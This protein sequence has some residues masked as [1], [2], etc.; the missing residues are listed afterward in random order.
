MKKATLQII[1]VNYNSND[2]LMA[3]LESIQR[4]CRDLVVET[5]V[6]DNGSKNKPGLAIRKRFPSIILVENEKN[7]GFAAAVNEV[8][9]QSDTPFILLLNPD[10]VIWTGF[11][12]KA[13]N[14]ILSHPD[15]G[16]MGPRIL[17]SDGSLQESARAFPNGLTAIFG[18]NS[19]MSRLFPNNILTKRNLLAG[20]NNGEKILEPDWVSG[21]CMFIRRAA[22]EQVG[23]MDERFFMYWEDTDWCRRMREK[24]WKVVYYPDA[25]IVHS[26]GHSSHS[27]PIHSSLEF[28]KSAYLLY[29]KYAKRRWRLLLLP[30]VFG[31]LSLRFYLIS[32]YK[33]LKRML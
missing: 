20:Q 18:R 10:T 23:L 15:I 22:V 29:E 14:H 7:I 26:V 8:L 33:I 19:L 17:N 1:I 3:C 16:V 28:H 12:H 30:V 11:F 32:I 5:W 4:D 9:R 2:A 13:L 24:G 6:W 31:A 25:S 27:R 21:A